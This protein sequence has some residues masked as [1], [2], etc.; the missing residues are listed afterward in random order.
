[1]IFWLKLTIERMHSGSYLLHLKLSK[2]EQAIAKD[3]LG[4]FWCFTVNH[5]YCHRG[6]LWNIIS[7]HKTLFHVTI[8]LRKQKKLTSELAH[9][10]YTHALWNCICSIRWVCIPFFFSCIEFSNKH[11]DFITV[12]PSIS[13]VYTRTHSVDAAFF[14][15]FFSDFMCWLLKWTCQHTEP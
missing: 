14:T 5:R 7:N 6:Q 1:M 4:N 8:I 2:D 3:S 12:S 9:K 13:F 10:I 15:F 11:T